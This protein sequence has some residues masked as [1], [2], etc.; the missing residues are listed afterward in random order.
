MVLLW[1]IRLAVFI[2]FTKVLSTHVDARYSNMI[3]R[4]PTLLMIK[5]ILIQAPLQALLVF[6]AYPLILDPVINPIWAIIGGGIFFVGFLG[7]I[8]ADHQLYKHKQS[9]T[10][11]CNIGLWKYSRHPNYFF[12]WLIWMG[13]SVTFIGQPLF[14]VSFIGPLSIFIIMYFITGPY[15]EKCSLKRRG[16]DYQTY[17]ETTPYFFPGKRL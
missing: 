13:I 14:G 10:K 7:E 15:T 1:G 9:S 3:K 16:K 5:Q 4:S 2:L 6:T 11:I 8:I 17:Q 12:E